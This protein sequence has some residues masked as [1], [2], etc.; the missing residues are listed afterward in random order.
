[1][2]WLKK[3]IEFCKQKKKWYYWVILV[4]IIGTAIAGIAT[5]LISCQTVKIDKANDVKITT[6]N[7][8]EI[9]IKAEHMTGETK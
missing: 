6:E 4:I 1:M 5:G 8:A 3:A 9:Q 2:E 7:N